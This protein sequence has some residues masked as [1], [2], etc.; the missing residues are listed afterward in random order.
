MRAHS[1]GARIKLCIKGNLE[2]TNSKD[3]EI[4]RSD[5]ICTVLQRMDSSRCY[6]MRCLQ[7]VC[8]LF[9]PRHL[10]GHFILAM[11]VASFHSVRRKRVFYPSIMSS[12]VIREMQNSSHKGVQL[13]LIAHTL[14]ACQGQHPV[15][16]PSHWPM[17]L[18]LK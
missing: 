10:V 6:S 12:F 16:E 18:L 11:L 4:E 17:G 3:S 2:G 14:L 7:Y 15:I 9:H 13:R 5:K 8:C 1:V